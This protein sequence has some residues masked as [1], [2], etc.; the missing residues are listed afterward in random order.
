[1][2]ANVSYRASLR[3]SSHCFRH[4]AHIRECVNLSCW[5]CLHPRV[6]RLHAR[7]ARLL[8][9]VLADRTVLTRA[10][11]ASGV[12]ARAWLRCE[13]TLLR[14]HGHGA[15]LRHDELPCSGFVG[16]I[17]YVVYRHRLQQQQRQR[18]LYYSYS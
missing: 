18:A 3:A 5:I 4:N 12:Q 9:P 8:V 2:Y 15:L 1:M 10:R 17:M 13:Q 16:Q 6:C 7:D 14:R 11:L